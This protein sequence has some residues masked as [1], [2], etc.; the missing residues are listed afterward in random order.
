MKY[1]AP[2]LAESSIL[3]EKLN[4]SSIDR[5]MAINTK[6]EIIAWNKTSELL[7][8]LSKGDVTT[9]NL[10]QIFPQINND[11]EMVEAIQ[12]AFNGMK[13]FLPAKP[14]FFNRQYIEN[15]FIPLKEDNG[16]VIGIMNIMHDVAH[17]IKAEKQ[18]SRL[19]AELERKFRQLEKANNDLASF[20]YV[21][22]QNIKEPIRNIYSSIEMLV[23]K[24]AQALSNLSRGNLRKIQASLN[25]MNLLLDDI[26][27][28]SHIASHNKS[29]EK[30]DLE[31]VFKKVVN[32]LQPKIIEKNAVIGADSLPVITGSEEMLTYLFEELTDNALKFQLPGT[33]P[34]LIISSVLTRRDDES[35]HEITFHDNGAGFDAKDADRIFD[36]FVKLDPSSKGSGVGLAI[37]KKIADMHDGTITAESIPGNGSTFRCYLPAENNP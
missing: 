6:H 37:C 10:F 34:R 21:T 31:L 27:T 35:F 36:M 25:K 7:T 9:K 16:K 28:I 23:R 13:S 12:N 20:T 2:Y 19:H 3:Y 29:F 24:E 11:V 15:H 32:D 26:V 18:L 4:D 5:V 30:V 8:G 17:R 33:Q 22:S 1:S 14:G